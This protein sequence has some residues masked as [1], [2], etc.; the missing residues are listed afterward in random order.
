MINRS[1]SKK[2]EYEGI[3]DV[4]WKNLNTTAESEGET[5]SLSPSLT[6]YNKKIESEVK[7]TSDSLN[8]SYL[9][10]TRV[11][12]CGDCYVMLCYVYLG[13]YLTNQPKKQ[14]SPFHFSQ[15]LPEYY[16]SMILKGGLLG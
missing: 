15:F 16:P 3:A 6:F 12:S 8:N 9:G 5:P 11:I 14:K 10:N 13:K 1:Y 4:Q 2:A 7:K